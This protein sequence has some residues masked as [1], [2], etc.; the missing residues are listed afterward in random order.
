M[1]PW[2][3]VLLSTHKAEHVSLQSLT[4]HCNEEIFMLLESQ[5]LCF[6]AKSQ[7]IWSVSLKRT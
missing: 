6:E 1:L 4:K 5:I 7:S 3:Q 2:D